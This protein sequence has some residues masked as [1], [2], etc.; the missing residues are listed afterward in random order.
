VRREHDTDAAPADAAGIGARPAAGGLEAVQRAVG[1]AG[2]QRLLARPDGARRLRRMTA[3]GA[4]RT[5][6]RWDWPWAKAPQLAPTE[7]ESIKHEFEVSPLVPKMEARAERER[8]G[9]HPPT[10]EKF[11]AGDHVWYYAH[12]DPDVPRIT[13]DLDVPRDLW[14]PKS[15][16]PTDYEGHGMEI[17]EFVVYA[18]HVKE[19]KPH[20][21]GKPGTTAWINNN[22][23]NLSGSKADVG[24]IKGKVN[25]HY[26][27]IFRT[28]EAG[29][30][31]IPKW[32][33]AYGYYAKSILAAMRAYAPASDGNRPD[34]YAADVVAALKGEK[35]EDGSEITLDTRLE[36]LSDTQMTKVQD[37]I[38]KAEGTIPGTTHARDSQNLPWEIRKRL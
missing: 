16:G 21:K 17:S 24:Q 27:L 38:K 6:A 5:L 37:A 25:W 35:T 23:G 15:T 10:P 29:Y 19:G 3:G 34:D 20:M 30:D 22:P 4:P 9:K 12:P 11:E 32:L 33:K 1:N 13:A 26:F 18:D 31:A 28:P 36:Q 2:M 14:F 7:E 8:A